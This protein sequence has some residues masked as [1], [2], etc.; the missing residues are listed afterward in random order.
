MVVA[1]K[2]SNQLVYADREKGG[3]CIRYVR[4]VHDFSFNFPL[5]LIKHIVITALPA[6][7][8]D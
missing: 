7:A 8:D 2:E 6:H 1:S 5:G 3:V 4:V